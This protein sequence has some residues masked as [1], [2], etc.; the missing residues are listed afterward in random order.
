MKN[1]ENL[2]LEVKEKLKKGIYLYEIK[3]YLQTKK[4]EDSEIQ[5]IIEKAKEIYKKEKSKSM[6]IIWWLLTIFSFTLFFFL[7]PLSFYNVSPLIISFIGGGIVIIFLVQSLMNFT[8]FE[9]LNEKNREKQDWRHKYVAYFVIPLLAL[10]FIFYYNFSSKEKSELN[11][12]GNKVKA[13]IINGSSLTNRKGGAYN[14]TIRFKT[15]KGKVYE[16]EENVTKEEFLTLH[17]GKEIDIIYSV[18]NPRMIEFLT[19]NDN[20]REYT[21]SEERELN[22]KDILDILSS[23]HSEQKTKLDK[24]SYGWSFKKSD[25]IWVNKRINSL[26]KVNPKKSIRYIGFGQSFFNFLKELPKSGFKKIEYGD[27]QT[28][29]YESEKYY[30]SLKMKLNGSTVGSELDIQIK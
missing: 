14:V 4:I 12:S 25:S 28:H 15:K 11:E 30:V 27:S 24:I 19:T 18:K 10:S 9:E 1:K 29:L 16:V 17:K 13:T 2:I 23:S 21:K 6:K 26:M 5:E 3:K 20:L 22:I 7:L 8:S